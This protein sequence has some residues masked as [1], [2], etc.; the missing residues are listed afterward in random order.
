[1]EHTP[2]LLPRHQ[3][4]LDLACYMSELDPTSAETYWF[5]LQMA[6]QALAAQQAFYDRYGLSEGK[7]VVL[8]LLQQAP[9]YRLAPSVL[10]EVA[11]VKRAT[12]TGL[13]AGLERSGWSNAC[14]TQKTGAW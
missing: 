2:R 12:I 13:L 10:A 8:L 5:F 4:F 1:M 11:G 3:V 9:H 7:L 6:R 14:R